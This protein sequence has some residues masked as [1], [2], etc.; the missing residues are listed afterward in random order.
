MPDSICGKLLP[1]CNT[2]V[3]EIENNQRFDRLD[4]NA[5]RA[6]RLRLCDGLV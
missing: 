4:R 2:I 3:I 1:H 6:R 5:K